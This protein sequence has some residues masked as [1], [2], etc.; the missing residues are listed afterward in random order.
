MEDN[1]KLL[2]YQCAGCNRPVPRLMARSMAGLK[3][4]PKYL[5]ECCV[6]KGFTLVVGDNFK[7]HLCRVDKPQSLEM[8]SEDEAVKII[9]DLIRGWE[10]ALEAISD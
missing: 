2:T 5:C 4:G 1:S 6:G 8:K 3:L 7:V 10:R 9:S